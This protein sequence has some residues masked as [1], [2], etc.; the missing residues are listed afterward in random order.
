MSDS[1][2]TQVTTLAAQVGL[3]GV[4]G[5]AVGYAVRTA[6]MLVVKI[7][8]FFFGLLMLFL[9]YLSSLGLVDVNYSGLQRGLTQGASALIRSFADLV[10]FIPVA[11][12][13]GGS[14]IAGLYIGLRR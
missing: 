4:A 7:A 14:F 8:A 3:G 9:G 1:L 12:P 6:V 13:L 10:A 11:L 5:F 2:S